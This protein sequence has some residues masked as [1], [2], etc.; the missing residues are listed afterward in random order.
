MKKGIVSNIKAIM[1]WIKNQGMESMSGRMDGH[2][3]EISKMTLGMVME[4][5]MI[6]KNAYIEAIGKMGS[7]QIQKDLQ[8]N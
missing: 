7:K 6:E 2:I 4:N 5:S 8:E 1:Q 3:K